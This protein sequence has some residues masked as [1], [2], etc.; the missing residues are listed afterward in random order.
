MNWMLKNSAGKRDGMWTLTVVSFIV[1]SF[2]VILS[3]FD[4]VKIG[5]FHVKPKPVDTALLVTYF[6][7]TGTGY[8]VRRNKKD[9]SVKV[10]VNEE[11]GD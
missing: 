7:L 2:N 9:G 4:E 1:I 10:D 8:V 11:L 5:S 6:G 3:M